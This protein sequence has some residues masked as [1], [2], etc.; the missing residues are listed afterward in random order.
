VQQIAPTATR[1][2]RSRTTVL[3][4]CFA[5]AGVVFAAAM[6]YVAYRRAG[7]GIPGLPGIT[8]EPQTAGAAQ[9]ALQRAIDRAAA[10]DAGGAWD[11]LSS[12]GQAMISRSDYV[13]YAQACPGLTGITAEI[14]DVRLETPTRALGIAKFLIIAVKVVAL[15]EAGRWKWD[16]LPEESA[17]W[18]KPLG[19]RIADAQADGSCTPRTS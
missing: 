3:F 7:V 11:L 9:A 17:G 13:A 18:S 8:A 5:L 1:P 15:Y 10:G 6:V 14:T 2:E 4:A 12:R 19:R 16:P